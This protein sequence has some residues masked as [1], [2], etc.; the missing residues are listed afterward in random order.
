MIVTC[1]SQ[2]KQGRCEGFLVS[3]GSS[4]R[5][6]RGCISATYGHSSVGKIK[7]PHMC[8]SHR[9]AQRHKDA[10]NTFCL[11]HSAAVRASC[12]YSTCEP[13][14]VRLCAAL[15]LSSSVMWRGSIPHHPRLL[16]P[17][18]DVDNHGPSDSDSSFR[19]GAISTA[20]C[21]QKGVRSNVHRTT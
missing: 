9:Q 20:L 5:T 7:D 14:R 17:A 12:A 2:V 18:S 19:P 4:G 1:S 15:A 11:H 3:C 16:R 8:L 21:F 10:A 6:G 13:R